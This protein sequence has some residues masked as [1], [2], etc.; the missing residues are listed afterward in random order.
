MNARRLVTAT[1]VM[2]CLGLSADAHAAAPRSFYGVIP[3]TDP[4]PTELA[5]M[6]AGRIGTLRINL[7]WG[8]VQPSESSPYDWTH[9][10]GVI[11]E[12]ARY[13]IQVLPTIYSSPTWAARKVNH[14]PAKPHLD[15]F[16]AFVS[17][18][19]ARFGPG[20]TFWATHPTIPSVPVIWW[21]LWNEPSFPTYWYR[22]PSPRQ[23]VGLLRLFH[24]AV[25]AASPAA[26][27]MLAGLFPTPRDQVKSGINL[28]RYLPAIYRRKAKPLFDAVA[29]HPYSPTPKAALRWVRKLRRLMA[30]FKDKRTPI[31]VTELGWASGG[32]ASPFTVSP[33]RQAAFVRKSFGLLAKNRRRLKIAGVIWYSWRDIPGALWINNTGLFTQDFGAKPSWNA[34]VSL[35]GGSPNAPPQSSPPPSQPSPLPLP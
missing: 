13:G 24:H 12:A 23:Y 20:G 3:A 16:R 22:K 14:P 18:A 25:K 4:D 8:A 17:A 35:T 10:D 5:R 11:G 30:R 27:I 1:T 32:A 2:I 19:V 9:Y 29:L 6:G 34:F 31:W 7:V 33:E 15:E 26:R 21:Q 28:D